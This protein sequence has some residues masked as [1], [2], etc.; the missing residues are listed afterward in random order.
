MVEDAGVVDGGG[1]G[2]EEGGEGG[3]KKQDGSIF[4]A[5]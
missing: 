4:G 5:V 1:M 3:Q 2:G